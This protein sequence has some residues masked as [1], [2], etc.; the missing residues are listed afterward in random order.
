MRFPKRNSV[1][2]VGRNK[3]RLPGRLRAT[4]QIFRERNAGMS[5]NVSRRTFVAAA[6]GTAALV[7]SG[8]AIALADDLGGVAD[9]TY[10]ATRPGVG[11]VTVTIV[12]EGGAI[13]D[14]QVDVSGETNFIGAQF[15]DLYASSIVDAQGTE[16]DTTTGATITCDAVKRAVADCIAQAKGEQAPASSVTD[17]ATDTDWLG[18]EPEIDEADVTETWDTDILI[19]GAGNGGLTAAVYAAKNGLNLAHQSF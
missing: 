6:A 7:A 16:F 10:S 5:E 8:S 2:G 19:V 18:S 11:D 12:I 3:E 15:G 13:T 4:R 9:G 14:A 17:N 1:G